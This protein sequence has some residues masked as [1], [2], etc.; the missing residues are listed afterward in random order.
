MQKPTAPSGGW[1]VGFR[2]FLRNLAQ[3]TRPLG[4]AALTAAA[5]H[6]HRGSEEMGH[7]NPLPGRAHR[8]SCGSPDT[9]RLEPGRRHVKRCLGKDL[10]SRI[11]LWWMFL[12]IR[13]RPAILLP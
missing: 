4:A 5:A 11:I 8:P 9:R 13:R 7:K 12:R 10:W 1:V 2:F 6:T 3:R